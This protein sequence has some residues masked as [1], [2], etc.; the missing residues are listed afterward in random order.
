MVEVGVKIQ[1]TDRLDRPKLGHRVYVKW[2]GG[3]ISNGTTN[4]S[5]IYDTEVSRGTIEWVEVYGERVLNRYNAGDNELI[6]VNISR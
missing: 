4:N 5:G 2:A 6:S 3:G 1:V